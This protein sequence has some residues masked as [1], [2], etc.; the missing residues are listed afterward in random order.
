MVHWFSTIR[1]LSFV[2]DMWT[3]PISAVMCARDFN[4]TQSEVCGSKCAFGSHIDSMADDTILDVVD[5]VS[6]CAYLD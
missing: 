3:T 4:V 5:R 1:D 2:S 6:C